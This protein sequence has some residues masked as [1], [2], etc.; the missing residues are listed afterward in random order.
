VSPFMNHEHEHK[1]QCLGVNDSEEGWTVLYECK[2]CSAWSYRTLDPMCRVPFSEG[3][4]E[5]L[6]DDDR[7]VNSG[8]DGQ[9]GG[10]DDE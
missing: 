9:T 4:V 2:D 7:P 1:W 6:V 10:S 5:A 8:V 3:Y